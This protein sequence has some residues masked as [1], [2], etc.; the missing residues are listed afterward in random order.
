MKRFLGFCLALVGLALGAYWL[1]FMSW[2]HNFGSPTFQR[3]ESLV[4][5]SAAAAIVAGVGLVVT[6]WL[7]RRKRE[8]T[9]R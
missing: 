8:R 4:T 6:D 9:S 5:C 1:L 3:K 2:S 7:Q